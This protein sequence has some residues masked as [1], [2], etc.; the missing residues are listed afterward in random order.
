MFAVDV[1][2][3][4]FFLIRPQSKKAKEQKNILLI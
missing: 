3:F 4:Y 2:C 1:C